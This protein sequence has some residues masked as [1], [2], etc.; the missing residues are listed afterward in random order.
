MNGILRLPTGLMALC[1][2]DGC[3]ITATVV[4]GAR[5]LCVEHAREEY[6]CY[7]ALAHL[8]LR[9]MS[10]EEEEARSKGKKS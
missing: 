7:K 10:P 8:G 5:H 6:A 9:P 3:E 2:E 1:D 4:V